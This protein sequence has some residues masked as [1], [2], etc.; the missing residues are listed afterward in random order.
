MLLML[1][2]PGYIHNPMSWTNVLVEGMVL[3]ETFQACL[4]HWIHP[5]KRHFFGLKMLLVVATTLPINIFVT[6]LTHPK[7]Q[8]IHGMIFHTLEH[9]CHVL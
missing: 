1:V 3:V 7:T 4:S 6:C 9:V 2:T 8:N 5:M